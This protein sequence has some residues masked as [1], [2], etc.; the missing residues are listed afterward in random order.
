MVTVDHHE[1]RAHSQTNFTELRSTN[2]KHW[3]K[4]LAHVEGNMAKRVFQI[5]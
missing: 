1:L 3:R 4:R 5:A 2:K